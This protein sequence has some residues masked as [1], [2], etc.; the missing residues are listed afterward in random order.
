MSLLTRKRLVPAAMVLGFVGV[1]A[2]LG[3]ISRTTSTAAQPGAAT[4]ASG[5]GA[6]VP[7]TPWYWTLAVSPSDDELL[8]LGTSKGLY[9]STD[10]GRAWSAT[11]P[12]GVHVTS[13]ALTDDAIVAGGVK[14]NTPNPVIRK[15][16][17]RTAPD[18]PAVLV[19][20]SDDGETWQQLKPR[21]LPKASIQSLA[22]DPKS[23]TLYALLNDGRLY[24]SSDGATSFSLVTPKLGIAPWAI[25]VAN[26]GRFVSG[27]MDSGS[28]V[29]ANAKQ[30]QN[31]PFKD[32]EGERMVMEY[33]VQPGES[34]R[35]IMSSMGMMVSPNNGKTWR[36]ALRSKIMFGPVAYAPSSPDVAYAVG[37]D[38]SLWRS[39]NGGETWKKVT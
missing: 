21:G 3:A 38:R 15:G 12:K 16:S 22:V 8:I 25:A 29:S 18:G 20:S 14:V 37:F 7:Y 1:L 4:T 35:M 31:T 39:E 26:D 19:S 36:L 13:L 6:M 10:G 32:S 27:D 34:T 2:A 24:R 17:G 28:H 33:A 11:G 5:G 9:R 30:W 23:T